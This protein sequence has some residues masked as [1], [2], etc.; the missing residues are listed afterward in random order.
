MIYENKCFLI[1]PIGKADSEERK[2]ANKIRDFLKY[3]VLSP[4]GYEC[5]R[6]DDINRAGLITKDVINH[7][8]DDELAL[9]IV[10]YKNVNV[11]YELAVRHASGKICFVIIADDCLN[12]NKSP[13]DT[14]QERTL[15]FPMEEMMSFKNGN[16]LS[17]GLIDFQGKLHNA[18][19]EYNEKRYVVDNPITLARN[20]F[21][22]LQHLTLEDV[23]NNVNRK[24]TEFDEKMI[25]ELESLKSSINKMQPDK[26]MD[27][28]N[29]M[30]NRDIA[31]YIEGED[32]AF[33]TL[34]EMTKKAKTSL[35]T[36]RF[37][38]QAIGETKKEFFRAFCEFGKK[39]DVTC[40]RI[41]CMN[42]NSKTDDLWQTVYSTYGGSMEL[43]LT[44]RDNNFELVVVDDIAAFLHFYDERRRIKSTLLIKGKSVI[45][46]FEKIYDQIIADKDYDFQQI[47]CG[48][49]KS[50]YEFN[51]DIKTAL[52]N[53]GVVS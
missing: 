20:D 36:S 5:I 42:E 28:L 50:P 15:A 39:K 23:I 27:T 45:R 7:I 48:K 41:M 2:R 24:M 38:P 31:T 11:Y 46:E 30:Y 19:E 21:Q 34:T 22:P 18:I 29:N 14:N 25:E 47:N 37:A 44:K 26:I 10:D 32:L 49:Y 43:Y 8:Y 35:R 40:K 6:A 1:S 17:P 52:A 4:L 53:L 13:F 51:E 16:D 9:A 12:N 3:K 33:E